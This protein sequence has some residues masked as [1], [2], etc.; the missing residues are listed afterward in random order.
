M[1]AMILPVNPKSCKY[2]VLL[3][4]LVLLCHAHGPALLAQGTRP[5]YAGSNFMVV[6]EGMAPDEI[7]ELAGD[8]TPTA[9]QLAWQRCEFNAFLHFGLNTFTNR[10]WGDGK[11]DPALFNPSR[12]DARQWAHA[13]RDAGMKM[14]II[15][16]KHHDGFCLWPTEYTGYSVKSSPWKGGQG[17]V[18]GELAEACREYGLKFGFYLSPWDR[19]EPSYGDSAAYNR[20][21][22]NQLRELLTRYGEISEVWFDG[23]CG[24]GPNGKK[25]VYDWPAWYALIR[26]LQPGAV[27]AVM[28]PDVRWVGTE[29]GVARETEWSVIPDIVDPGGSGPDLSQPFPADR[30]FIPRDRMDADLGS[31]GKLAGAR[32]LSWY[33][34]E[35]DVSIRP[36]WFWHKEEN[37]RVKSPETLADLWFKSVGRN[38]V[39]LLNIPPDRRGLIAKPDLRSLQGMRRILDRA[40][41]D[42]RL[43]NSSSRVSSDTLEYTLAQPAAFNVAMLR[44][45]IKAGQRIEAFMLEAWDG[46]QWTPF[47]SGTTVGNRRLLR[48]PAV[49]AGKIRLIVAGSRGQWSLMDAGLYLDPSADK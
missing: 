26:E 15:T 9:R 43:E 19:H 23:A 21:F 37:R 7:A 3:L 1:T 32:S 27:I 46:R 17:D 47:A 13:I 45:D 42:N 48:F 8:V 22:M 39:L 14:A 10:E 34:A 40:F 16:A 29:T 2:P 44:E 41:R 33:P 5:V 18:V 11:G 24:E 49:N 6:P 20:F 12:L 35:A 36:G 31:H 4:L 38:A 25:Q 30:Y 28:G